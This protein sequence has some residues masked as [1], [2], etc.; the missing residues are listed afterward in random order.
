MLPLYQAVSTTGFIH[1]LPVF[2][3]FC[4]KKKNTKKQNIN[5]HYAAPNAKHGL[6]DSTRQ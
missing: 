4:Q 5:I 6:H 3:H 1:V 2:S